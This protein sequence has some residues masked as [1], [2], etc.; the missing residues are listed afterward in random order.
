[1][2]LVFHAGSEIVEVLIDQERV[3]R[4]A[5]RNTNGCFVSIDELYPGGDSLD[6]ETTKAIIRDLKEW[7]HVE[8][9]VKYEFLRHGLQHVRTEW[10]ASGMT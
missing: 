10:E 3:L 6:V 8:H 1:M 4:F 2:K 7:R 9:Y 5:G